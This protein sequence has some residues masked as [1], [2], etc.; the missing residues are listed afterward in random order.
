MLFHLDINYF[1]LT[2][3][4]YYVWYLNYSALDINFLILGNGLDHI[5][6]C[7]FLPFMPYNF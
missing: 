1:L 6:V 5:L 2:M 3:I 4:V 7:T